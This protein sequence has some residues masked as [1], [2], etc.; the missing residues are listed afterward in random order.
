MA[1]IDDVLKAV[2]DVSRSVSDAVS[3]GNYQN[4]S[5][6]V[7]NSL[8]NFGVYFPQGQKNPPDVV[9]TYTDVT[10][11][12]VPDKEIKYDGDTVTIQKTSKSGKKKN[13]VSY[14]YEQ[15]N[16]GGENKRTAYNTQYKASRT[17]FLQ[18]TVDRLS[19]WIKII[20]G[21]IGLFGF[22]IVSLILFGCG[23]SAI[24]GVTIPWF[25]AG[26][27]FAAGAVGFGVLFG[28]G[29]DGKNL[30]DRYYHYSRVVGSKEYFSIQEVADRLGKK[31]SEVIKDIKRM[32]SRG[33]L[34]SAKF[35][36]TQT[37]VMLTDNAF[38]QYQDAELA[39]MKR[40]SEEERRRNLT[41]LDREIEDILNDG[42]KYLKMI[43]ECN[44]AIPDED[45]TN[46]LYRLENIMNRIFEQVKNSPESASNLRRLMDYYLP[47]TDKLLKAYVDLDKQP[48]VGDNIVNTKREIS[49]TLGVIND[50]F[51]KL[52]DSMFENMAWDISSDISVMRSMMEQD[53]L[54]E[55]KSDFKVSV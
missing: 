24:S 27:A 9:R 35:D 7:K 18:R 31:T 38:K 12:D 42:E 3:S 43:R 22:A 46:K 14:T 53:G 49:D 25:I 20:A 50:A 48:E 26:G 51:E 21:G 16:Y 28:S 52:L 29:L 2:D 6:D 15:N 44:D 36:E 11:K 4:L 1:V 17:P 39:R 10:V 34:P 54:M 55:N 19:E 40:E 47:T 45:V 37:T 30:V 23:F 13:T 32:I 41:G 5:N 8:A 33:F